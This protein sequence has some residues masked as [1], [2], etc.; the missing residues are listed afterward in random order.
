M[1]G[2]RHG[3]GCVV[4]HQFEFRHAG[5]HLPQ[6]KLSKEPQGTRHR[7]RHR[8]NTAETQSD[9]GHLGPLL[10]YGP[11]ATGDPSLAA[12]RAAVRGTSAN[13]QTAQASHAACVSRST[14]DD[15]GRRPAPA[16]GRQPT[17]PVPAGVRRIKPARWIVRFSRT[18]SVCPVFPL[19]PAFPLWLVF[20][21]WLRQP[22]GH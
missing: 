19:W 4:G 22:I 1:S 2:P 6:Q 5:T 21:L 13:T 11:G 15:A 14:S 17:A 18:H 8:R 16:T 10:P 3:R 9:C 7:P 12:R 20:P